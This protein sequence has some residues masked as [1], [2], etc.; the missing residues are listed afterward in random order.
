[1]TIF[2]L[3]RVLGDTFTGKLSFPSL[4][5]G[6]AAAWWNFNSK[7]FVFPVYSIKEISAHWKPP[8]YLF[9]QP[10]LP[11]LFISGQNV[12]F[13]VPRG[14]QTLLKKLFLG[15][16]QVVLWKELP[17]W[18][19][20]AQNK[21]TGLLLSWNLILGGCGWSPEDHKGLRMRWSNK[22]STKRSPQL[23]HSL[24]N[25]IISSPQTSPRI[26]TKVTFFRELSV[27]ALMF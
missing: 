18:L 11:L 19:P 27:P 10:F 20:D 14:V 24:A 7:H 13:S 1:M 25:G 26:T 12:P 17:G 6:S 3:F 2:A 23:M 8:Q 21:C 5:L 22:Y 16:L 9:N 15:I 4:Q